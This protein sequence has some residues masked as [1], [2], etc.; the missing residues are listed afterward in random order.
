MIIDQLPEISTVQTTDEIPIERLQ[1]TYKT[2]I[3]KIGSAIFASPALTGTPTAPTAYASTDNTQIATTAFANRAAK[4]A[5]STYTRPN[6]LDN[7]FFVGGGSQL[8][9]GV[10]PIN[11]R[12]LATVNSSGYHIDRWTNYNIT[13]MTL[14]SDGITLVASASGFVLNQKIASPA[15]CAGKTLTA[16]AL[17]SSVSGGTAGVRLAVGTAVYS[18]TTDLSSGGMSTITRKLTDS[19]DL[20]SI[21]LNIRLSSGTTAKLVAV[22]LEIGDTQTLVHNEGTDANPVWVLN[23]LPDYAEQLAKCQ[24]YY[25]RMPTDSTYIKPV[26]YG[27]STNATTLRI[28][29]PLPQVMFKTPTVTSS[30]GLVM[31]G[32]HGTS[33]KSF[34]NPSFANTYLHGSICS[35][36]ITDSGLTANEPYTITIHGSNAFLEFTADIT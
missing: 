16:T 21:G 28:A 34:T 3:S 1:T 26:G 14:D 6:L 8:G 12:G 19:N 24:R 23:E 2:Q 35:T 9:Y 30:S 4:N 17:F 10:F 29:I 36:Q 32:Y 27:V 7:W 22:K 13:S 31:N 15:S 25:F 5:V 20:T 18:P 33:S 11:Q